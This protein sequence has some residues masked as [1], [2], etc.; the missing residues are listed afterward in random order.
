MLKN[1][2]CNMY[3]TKYLAYTCV[4]S[5]DKVVIVSLDGVVPRWICLD[6][7]QI[8]TGYNSKLI[9]TGRW[10]GNIFIFMDS[11]FYRVAL[12][13]QEVVYKIM[14]LQKTFDT[15]LTLTAS[16]PFLMDTGHMEVHTSAFRTLFTMKGKSIMYVHVSF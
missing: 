6:K 3:L 11:P 5:P 8:P 14:D 4:I 10:P 12:V 9:S 15:L 7:Q 1:I 2:A 16:R 13:R